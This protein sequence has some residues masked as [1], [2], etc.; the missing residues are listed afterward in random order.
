MESTGHPNAVHVSQDT[1]DLLPNEA[2]RASGGVPVKGKGLMQ[3]YILD[4]TAGEEAQVQLQRVF[5][6]Y[7]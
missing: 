3:T 7:L 5:G 1:R 4:G 2:F 6:V